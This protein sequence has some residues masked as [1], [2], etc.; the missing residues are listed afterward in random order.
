MVGSNMEVINNSKS[1]ILGIPHHTLYYPYVVLTC[2]YQS[3]AAPPVETLAISP[4]PGQQ[5]MCSDVLFLLFLSVITF[6]YIYQHLKL[7]FGPSKSV[8][9]IL[10]SKSA[11]LR[12]SHCCLS[13]TC[14]SLSSCCSATQKVHTRN[15]TQY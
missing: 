7:C 5:L 3:P 8:K 10:A 14:R 9:N 12:S 15:I 1:E 2:S 6:H 13:A 4:V 11:W